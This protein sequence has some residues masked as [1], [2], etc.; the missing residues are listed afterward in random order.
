M[1]GG[2]QEFLSVPAG[3]NVQD[4]LREMAERTWASMNADDPNP[5]N[6][7]PAEKHSSTEHLILPLADQHAASMQAL[8]GAVNIPIDAQA[9]QDTDPMFCYFARFSD[10]QGRHL[11]ALRRSSQ[12]KGVVSSRGWLVRQFDDELIL[13]EDRVFKL[14]ADFDLLIDDHHVHI[15]RPSGFEFA[16]RLQDAIR[17]AVPENIAVLRQSVAIVQ[18]D[19]VEAY[20]MAH[21][22]AARYLASI[23]QFQNLD[24]ISEQTLSVECA[25]TDVEIEFENGVATIQQAHV[26][27]FLE[28]LDRRRYRVELVQG[29]PERFRAP[30]RRAL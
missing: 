19:N 13:L 23:R 18:W 21:P 25:S 9:L 4:A 8:H 28:V 20:A 27:G 5:P 15:W 7:N 11:T 26:M 12:F 3:A 2:V 6:Y 1:A 24:L 14:D 16:G 30:N 17:A 10:Q 22:R 29:Q